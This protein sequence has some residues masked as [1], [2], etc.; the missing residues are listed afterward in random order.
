[1]VLRRCL[2]QFTVSGEAV[3]LMAEPF[4][5]DSPRWTHP[6]DYS[7]CQQM[8]SSVRA[9]N[10]PLIQYQSVRDPLQR[11]AMAVMSSRGISCTKPVSTEDWDLLISPAHIVWRA[12][13]S[14]HQYVIEPIEGQYRLRDS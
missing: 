5:H 3:N 9:N 14:A 7:H 6:S 11:P 1:M 8:G 10:I 4:V 13:Y 2:F 12:P